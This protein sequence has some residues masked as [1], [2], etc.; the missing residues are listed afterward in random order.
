MLTSAQ[1]KITDI[2]PDSGSLLSL[3]DELPLGVA[4]MDSQ[5]T[6]LLINKNYETL[7]GIAREKAAGLGCLHALR[8]DYCTKGCPI[9]SGWKEIQGQSVEATIINRE[10]KKIAINLTVSPLLDNNGEPHG[11]VETIAAR[12]LQTATET[13]SGVFGLGDLVGKSPQIQKVFAMVPPIAQT[14]SSVLITGE[15]GTGK[16]LLAEE[17][18]NASDRSDGPFV[19]V[20]CGALPDNLLESELFGHS[21]GAFTG[22]DHDKPGRFRM[23]HGGTLFLTEI[24]D[25]PLPLQVKLLSFLDDKVIHP[26]GSTRSFHADVRVIVATHRNLEEMVTDKR[27]RQDLLYRLNVIR[28]HMP[29]LRDRGEDI[30][31]LQDHFLKMFLARFN[32][33][34]KGLSQ[35][36]R[37]L[38]QGY[39]YPGNVREL[40]NIIE[41]AINFCDGKHLR[42]R[43]LPSYLLQAPTI[44]TEK[45]TPHA[46]PSSPQATMPPLNASSPPQ[47]WEDVQRNMILD[48]LT[49]TGGRKQKAA[50]LLGWGRSTLW[51]KMKHF[52]ID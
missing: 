1:K 26:L 32:K 36:A 13:V 44:E 8:C 7:T 14:D 5:G 43:H 48:A 17:I 9:L 27:F 20:N 50:E 22:A 23:A 45:Q 10:R 25:L 30:L 49:Q 41:Y 16:D 52:R 34:V 6:L 40:R 47:N 38:L 35:N 18:H 33:K 42:V 21:K 37:T 28:L 11:I 3:L 2:L 12:G 19:K 15:T 24:G 29:P 39:S 46:V 4:I 31:L 51:R